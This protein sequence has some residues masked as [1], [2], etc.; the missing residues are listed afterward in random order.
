MEEK[1]EEK[2]EEGEDE[3]KEQE[4]TQKRLHL[5]I[6]NIYTKNF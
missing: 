5:V 6:E 2:E 1:E 4:M 3:E